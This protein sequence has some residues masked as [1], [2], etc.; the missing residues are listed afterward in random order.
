MLNT[1][2]VKWAQKDFSH[3]NNRAVSERAI[4]QSQSLQQGNPP[5]R[6]PVVPTPHAG[7]ARVGRQPLALGLFDTTGQDNYGKLP[8]PNQSTDAHLIWLSGLSVS[9]DD[10]KS[11]PLKHP[12]PKDSFLTYGDWH[13]PLRWFFN[14]ET[15]LEDEQKPVTL[16]AVVVQSL[17]HV[18]LFVTPWTVA[19]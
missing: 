13:W 12:L 18:R 5:R 17:S 9:F 3:T 14:T 19:R 7:A 11:G 8:P 4:G 10:Q 16:V 6:C 2:Y 15:L 1:K